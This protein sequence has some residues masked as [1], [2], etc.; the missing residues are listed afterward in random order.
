M[1]WEGLVFGR[2]A[3][4]AMEMAMRRKRAAEVKGSM[5]CAFLKIFS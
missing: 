5:I 4:E 1:L 3:A 2:F